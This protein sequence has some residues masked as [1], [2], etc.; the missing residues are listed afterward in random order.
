L[1]I[2]GLEPTNRQFP[3]TIDTTALSGTPV[4][5]K[6]ERSSNARWLSHHHAAQPI[7]NQRE[8]TA[9]PSILS[10][11][12]VTDSF[13]IVLF[14]FHSSNSRRMFSSEKNFLISGSNRLAKISICFSET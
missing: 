9:Y 1:P 13:M 7:K 5:A 14:F 3:E 11:V 4:R 12:Y 6:Y 8:D 10:L 2:C